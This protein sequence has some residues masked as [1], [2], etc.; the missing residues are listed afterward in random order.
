MALQH[1]RRID[2]G[3]LARPVKRADGSLIVQ[4]KFSRTGVQTYTNADGSKRREYR[5]PTEVGH[6]DSLT[7]LKLIPFTVLHPPVMVTTEN[8]TQFS[9]G[10]TGETVNFDGR[11]TSG[12]IA[13]QTKD[14]VDALGRMTQISVGYECDLEMTP[15]VSPEG[16]RYDC[17]QRNIRGN[18]VALVPD[19][20]A[21]A[22]AAVRMDASACL[23]LDLSTDH[24]DAHMDTAALTAQLTEALT[25][26]ATLTARADAADGKV[27][28]L[29]TQLGT[30]T[31]ERDSQK[32][33]ADKADKERTDAVAANPAKVKA[34]VQLE[35]KAREILGKRCDA[36]EGKDA[37]VDLDKLDDRSV[38]VAVIKHVTNADCMTGLAG[39]DDAY[40]DAYVSA[41]YDAA[42]E[43]A[44]ASADTFRGARDTIE[45][46]RADARPTSDGA[47]KRADARAEM[48]KSNRTA[49]IPATVDK[50]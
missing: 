3:E 17:V 48:I 29:T 41:R 1:V 26:I 22:E 19:A 25:K 50:K 5:P 45:T 13:V 15:G 18:H 16:E 21:G 30:M 20:R 4:A 9:R 33:R 14:G 36:A 49:G 7:S 27:K 2:R 38:Q 35:G 44:V 6:A 31:A 28:D 12:T 47:Q 23:E 43:R 39:K 37:E 8:A 46:N 34:R 24:K 10:T 11:W 40:I 32:E 42:C